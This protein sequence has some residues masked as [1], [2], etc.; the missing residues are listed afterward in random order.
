MHPRAAHLIDAL[1]LLPHPEGGFFREVYRSESRVQPL[2]DR[3][4]RRAVTTIYFLL[5]SG[6]VSRWHQVL[7]D[8]VWHHYEGDPLELLVA[9]TALTRVT[10]H[11]LGP[12]GDRM[13]PVYVVRAHEWQAARSTGGYTLA[14][15]TVAPGFEFADFR[16]IAAE[17]EQAT[18]VRER[19]ADAAQFL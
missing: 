18:A 15:C 19:H 14:G 16:M 11:V 5:A 3:T 13:R 8:E 12:V 2:D 6:A 1:G 17:S 9:D 10:R 4:A 7:S